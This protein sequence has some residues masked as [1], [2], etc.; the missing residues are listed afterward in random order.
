MTGIANR[1]VQQLRI[2]FDA[3]FL[4]V[5]FPKDEVVCA[6]EQMTTAELMDAAPAAPPSTEVISLFSYR[7]HL[8]KTLIWELKYKGNKR[9]AKLIAT[10]LHKRILQILSDR[11]LADGITCPVVIPMPVSKKRRK[12]RGYNQCELVTDELSKMFGPSVTI[13]PQ[14]L[15]KIKDTPRQTLMDRSAR[16]EN[17]KG[18]FE[19][20]DPFLRGKD[21]FLID[22]V[23]T[24]GA[25]MKEAESVLLNAEARKVVKMTICR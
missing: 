18:C 25:T 15:R 2:F 10:V 11:S 21:I 13:L 3:A 16:L 19:S 6:L 1:V 5:L 14:G 22:D 17:I 7:N 4:D 9:V 20:G 8:V 24:T 12:E 23:F